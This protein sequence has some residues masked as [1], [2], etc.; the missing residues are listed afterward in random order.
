MIR[1]VRT[2]ARKTSATVMVLGIAAVFGSMSEPTA[3]AQP[4]ISLPL[5]ERPAESAALEPDPGQRSPPSIQSSLGS[6]GDP[7]D[8]RAMLAKRGIFY[9]VLYTNEV[10]GNVS[11]G[12]RRGP[13]YAGKLETA[14]TADLDTLAG[15][16]GM[17]GFANVFQLHDTGGLRDR[18]FQRLITV[19]N[20]E[21]FPTT[22]LSELWL[23]RRWNDNRFGLRFGQLVADGEFFSSDTGKLFLS[24]DWP[25][26]TGANLPSGGPAYPLST[27]G[28]RFRWDP[29]A[30]R[31]ALLAVF[32]GD[33]GDQRFVNT[34]G[35]NFRLNDPPLV[36]G[37]LQV[38]KGQLQQSDGLSGSVKLGFYRHFGR[39]DDQ[40]YD[41][42][43]LS[44]ANPRSSGV[45][46]RLRGTGGVYGVIDQQIYRPEGGA[47]ERG[48]SIYSR[49][50]WS[51]S[52]RNLIDFWADGGVVVTGLVPGRPNDTFGASLIYARISGGARGADRDLALASQTFQPVRSSEATIEVSYQAQIVPGWLVQPD[53]QYVFNPAGGIANPFIPNAGIKGGAVFGLRST[54]TY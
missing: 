33:P 23:E 38:R 49:L 15:W 29:D 7:G 50:S 41:T 39:F 30:S 32:N 8:F 52:D 1:S 51:P 20:I 14:I 3:L 13:I 45:A 47:S 35:T 27:P 40:R 9:N 17:S 36:M 19:S 16:T 25:T 18:S 26:I 54:V 6:F 28:V 10:L 2:R 43:G 34:T 44:L 46:R 22:R 11:G 48:V 24:N 4:G 31:S 5:N 21:A 42:A 37:E 12:I 53:F